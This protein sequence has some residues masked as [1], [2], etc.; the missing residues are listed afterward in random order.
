MKPNRLKIGT[1][2]MKSGRQRLVKK[3]QT[4]YVEYNAGTFVVRYVFVNFDDSVQPIPW[5]VDPNQMRYGH[6]RFAK[7][8]KR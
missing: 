2:Q 6:Q 3:I 5:K 4:Q 8:I 7:T 1:N